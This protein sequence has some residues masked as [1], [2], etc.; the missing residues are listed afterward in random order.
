MQAAAF[1]KVGFV[2]A[3]FQKFGFVP[4]VCRRVG[5]DSAVYRDSGFDLAVCRKVDLDSVVYPRLEPVWPDFS[6]NRKFQNLFSFL[7]LV[8]P[9][10][11]IL[12]D[13][14]AIFLFFIKVVGD[15]ER[16]HFDSLFV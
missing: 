6:E 9:C 3:V 2:P 4:V 11:R 1:R 16:I 13:N 7:V 15:I 10:Q 12:P 14:V 8:K 5:R